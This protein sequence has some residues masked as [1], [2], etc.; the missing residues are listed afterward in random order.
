MVD[1]GIPQ[2][3]KNRPPWFDFVLLLLVP[4]LGLL[5]GVAAVRILALEGAPYRDLVVNL[6]FLTAVLTAVFVFQFSRADVGLRLIRQELGWHLLAALAIFALYLLYYIFAIH[7]SGLNPLSPAVTWGLLTALIIA[8]AEEL[9][10]R[11]VLYRFI[12]QRYSALGAWTLSALIF[13]LFHARQGVNGIVTKTIT[14]W[15]WGSVRYTSGMIFLLIFPVHFAYNAFWLIFIGS[16]DNPPQWAI[17]G[18]PAAEFLLGL[19]I[20]WVKLKRTAQ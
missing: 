16:W 8:L 15:L 12:E 1:S 5:L 17:Y 13:G 7:I 3:Q 11:G 9:Y 10:F 6:V 19:A 14:G 2:E 20:A 18:L 4:I